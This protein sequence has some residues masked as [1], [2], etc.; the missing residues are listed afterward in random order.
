MTEP[1]LPD[2]RA[3]VAANII[4]VHMAFWLMKTEPSTFGID[5][6]QHK[7]REHWD[8]VRNFVARNNMKAMRL[9]DKAFVYHSSIVPPGIAGVAEIVREAYPDHT[10]FDPTSK[11]F[12]EKA[13]EEKPRWHMVDVGFERKFDRLITLDELK[14][15]PGLEDMMVTTKRGSRLSVQPVSEEHWNVVMA[16]AD[17]SA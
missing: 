3:R 10:Q 11:Y 2:A 8:G 7:G 12:D 16:L 13:T 14:R 1:R 9:G 6:L 17:G 4:R 5:D 15:T